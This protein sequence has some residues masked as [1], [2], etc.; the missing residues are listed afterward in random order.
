M[1]VV[2]TIKIEGDASGATAAID[3]LKKKVAELEQ[4]LA[5]SG[6][7]VENLGKQ[8]KKTSSVISKTFKGLGKVIT[9]PFTAAKK[10]ASGL[11]SLLKGGLGFGLITA[12]IDKASD[13]FS[14][15]QG[16]VD[17]LNKVL[18]TVSII[19]N[20]I[21]VA[22]GDVLGE[23]AAMNGGFDATKKV[24]GGL[25]SGVLNIFVGIIQGLQLAVLEVQLAW[26]Q[27]FFGDG[28][29]TRIEE[30]NK[31]I[32]QT[33]KELNETGEALLESGKMVINNIAEAAQ[34]VSATVVAVAKRVQ[35]EVKNLDITD[36]VNQATRLVELQKQ[37]ELA[38]V[39]RQEIQLKFQNTQE[40]LR[41]LR[42]DEMNSI[43]ARQD[44]NNKLLA[45]FELQAEK[46][47]E[48]LNIK[49]AAAAAEYQ[50]SKTNENIIKLKQAQLELTDLDERLQGQRSEALSN[51]N[52]LLREQLDLVKSRAT[53]A[54]EVFQ[55]EKEAG[56]IL[57]ENELERARKQIAIDEE[58]YFAKVGLL[59]NEASL[60]AEGTQARIDAENEIAMLDAEHN[61][62]RLEYGKKEKDAALEA[63]AAKLQMVAD[64]FSAISQLSAAFADD[65]EK[66]KKKQFE[67]QKKLS[68]ASA[69]VA[70]IQAVQNA[71]KTAAGSPIT[72]LLPA[73]PFI[74]AGL[75]GAFASAQ[76]AAISRT[77]YG[78]GA[79][80]VGSGGSSPSAPSTPPS[81]NVVGQGGINQ[82]AESIGQQNKNPVRAYVVGGDVTTSQELERKRIKTATFG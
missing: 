3:A 35:D 42:D 57:I 41:Q 43:E 67:L 8:G 54:L 1:A 50:I 66:S 64:G 48:Q 27:S 36:A 58:V 28:D 7:E 15:N 65:D 14:T 32:A 79:S 34:E 25:I 5:D 13:A 24:L 18:G 71:F 53:S 40:Q 2:E 59:E 75:A 51:Q 78:G 44:A 77:Q 22:I 62:K 21:A 29:I 81:F 63:Q 19:F 38:D 82:L 9:A 52:A 60:Y 47:R 55:L 72:E 4:E 6:E 76:V 20:K 74:Q 39:R 70:G 46:E 30:L 31:G 68:I 11:G 33:K 80:S 49:V 26:E 69:V 16:V 17:S 10:A 73:Y 56:L 37:A 12:A 23:Q 45:S 61:A